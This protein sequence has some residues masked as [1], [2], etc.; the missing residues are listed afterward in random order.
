MKEVSFFLRSDVMGYERK[1]VS[2]GVTDE[3]FVMKSATVLDI[4]IE[5]SGPVPTGLPPKDRR[6]TE[7]PSKFKKT[8]LRQ[9]ERPSRD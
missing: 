3:A 9:T 5:T 8:V 1:V 4:D 6:F 2:Q 7:I